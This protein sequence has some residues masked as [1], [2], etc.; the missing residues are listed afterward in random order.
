MRTITMII[1]AVAGISITAGSAEKRQTLET[2]N[3]PS[4]LL[5]SNQLQRGPTKRKPVTAIRQ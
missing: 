5:R 2:D 4:R 3:S 1:V